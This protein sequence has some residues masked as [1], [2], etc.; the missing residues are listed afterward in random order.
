MWRTERMVTEF[1]AKILLTG[2][3]CLTLM[4]YFTRPKP[5]IMKKFS[6]LLLMVVTI[7]AIAG[8]NACQS[9]KA[10]TGKT[11]QFNLQKGKTYDYE[12]VGDLDQEVLGQKYKTNMMDGYRSM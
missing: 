7:F 11:L 1:A 4:F 9:S 3:Y 6:F 8:I 2:V 5:A 10:S 12:M